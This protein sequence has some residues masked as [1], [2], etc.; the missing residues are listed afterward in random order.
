MKI[1]S[2]SAASHIDWR[3]DYAALTYDLIEL[4]DDVTKGVHL[5]MRS[6]D[7]T[8]GALDFIVTPDSEFVFLELNAGGQY[9]WLEAKTGVQ[10]T[11]YLAD[12][13]MEGK[14]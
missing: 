1:S 14:R 4:P 2:G 10:L 6:F 7:L 5:L 3:S 12:V 9:G 11:G 8:Y 13:L